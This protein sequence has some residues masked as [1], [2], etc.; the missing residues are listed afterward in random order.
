[1][2]GRW[3][4]MKRGAPAWGVQ[5]EAAGLCPSGEIDQLLDKGFGIQRHERG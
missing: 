2:E 5:L 3:E 1:M 4:V